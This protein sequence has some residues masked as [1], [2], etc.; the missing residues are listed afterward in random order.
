MATVITGQ[1]IADLRLKM[2]F[3]ALTRPSGWHKRWITHKYLRQLIADATGFQIIGRRKP[4]RSESLD[5][6]LIW[7]VANSKP[8]N[9]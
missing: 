6:Y 4:E 8:V 9:Q 2:A 7:L 1:G 3:D 5:D